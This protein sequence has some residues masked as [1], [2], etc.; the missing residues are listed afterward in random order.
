MTQERRRQVQAGRRRRTTAIA[1][2]VST[3]VVAIT[4][5]I[6]GGATAGADTEANRRFVVSAGRDLLGRDP[7]AGEL[8]SWTALLDAGEPRLV[9][10]RALAHS[11]EW[12]AEIA[13]ELFDSVLDRPADSV[14]LRFWTERL[15]QGTSPSDVAV[16]LATSPESL[17]RADGFSAGIVVVLYQALLGR[18]ADPGGLAHFAARIDAGDSPEELAVALR[19]SAESRVRRVQHLYLRILERTADPGGSEHW[20][21]Q[22]LRVDDR[23]VAAHLAASAEYLAR[24]I[25]GGD[26]DPGPS[27]SRPPAT[28]VPST[29]SSQPPS[30]ETT[31]TTTTT[32]ST[33]TTTTTVPQHPEPEHFTGSVADFYVVPDPLPHGA[34]GTL[35]RYQDLPS[36]SEWVNRRIM[37]HSRDAEG[38]DRAVTGT[39][40]F[41]TATPPEGGWPVVSFSHGTTG[42][43]SQ[44]A[45]SRTATS[46]PRYGVHGVSVATDYI[47]LGPVG[48]VH[49]YLSASAEGHAA[50]DAVR[51]ASQVPGANAGTE[52][53]SV[54]GS[55]GAHSALIAGE[56][57]ATYAPELTLLGT[58]AMAPPA[59]FDQT[60]GALDVVVTNIIGVMM[61]YGMVGER[62]DVDPDDY[63]GEQVA[64]AAH[65]LDEQCLGGITVEFANKDHAA[66][67]KQDPRLVEPTRSYVMENEP[68][69]IAT[70]APM[71]VSSGTAD[72]QVPIG[73]VHVLM[74]N[75][76]AV[77][78]VVEYHE[79]EGADHG[80]VFARSDAGV[81]RF[82][83]ERLAGDPPT[84][85][86]PWR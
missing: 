9:V 25:S 27:S 63:V 78:Q 34:P 58:A 22:L 32:T 59:A 44:C 51:A 69:L 13:A 38:R 30:T 80:G 15:L 29:T 54:G 46:S 43:A 66:F 49:P 81:T 55:Q 60:F 64:A 57:N 11:P 2:A 33:T 72:I 37:Y 36:D 40:T 35:V 21:A 18:S 70:P 75:L 24:A 82:L 73:R 19:R 84:N 52:W 85:S 5:A 86:C 1:T 53:L 31:S 76:C 65:V 68:G 42:I 7:S 83:A 12:S 48:E 47:G 16:A 10:T 20:A 67:W 77:G 61:L 28:S 79:F 45:P 56:R 50:I 3:L 39:I 6:S 71:Y 17:A 26:G 4:V 41:P 8:R 14:G 62:S 74:D 23:E